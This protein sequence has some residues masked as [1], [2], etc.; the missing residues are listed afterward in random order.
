M[1][2]RHHTLEF[3][4]KAR[5]EPRE[6][7]CISKEHRDSLVCVCIPSCPH[8]QERGTVGGGREPRSLAEKLMPSW[9]LPALPL[10]LHPFTLSWKAGGDPRA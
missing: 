7:L 1:S 8:A 10:H 3:L 6:E 4:A 2:P 9:T 5:R